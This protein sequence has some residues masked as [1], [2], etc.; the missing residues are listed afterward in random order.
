MTDAPRGDHPATHPRALPPEAVALSFIDCINRLD[1]DG[2]VDLMTDDHQ[3]RILDEDPIAGLDANREAW[4]GYFTAFPRYVIYPARI[5]ARDG[6]VAILGTT[7]GSHLGLPDDEERK[8]EVLWTAEARDGRLAA[9]C[10]VP[11]SPEQR[12]RFGLA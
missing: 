4:H 9:W 10:I 8:L 3:L 1:L 6:A 5:A 2:L 12:A 11:D 7:T